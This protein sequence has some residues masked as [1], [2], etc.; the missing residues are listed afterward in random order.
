MSF[1]FR[2]DAFAGQQD[3]QTHIREALTNALNKKLPRILEDEITVLNLDWGDEAPAI[4]MLEIGDVALDRFRGVFKLNYTGGATITVATKVQANLLNVYQ[5][6]AP[7]QFTMPSFVDAQSSFPIPLHLTLRNIRLQGTVIVVFSKSKGLTLVFRNDP[8]QSIEVSSTFDTLPAIASYLQQ[9]IEAQIR[10]LFREELPA[11]LY[12]LSLRYLPSFSQSLIMDEASRFKNANKEHPVTFAEIEAEK[13]VSL[14]NLLH[15]E[16]MLSSRRTLALDTP[17]MP[18]AIV[19]SE[20][21][22]RS[23]LTRL[24]APAFNLVSD[25]NSVFDQLYYHVKHSSMRAAAQKP[26]RR[27]V[28]KL[29]KPKSSTEPTMELP[30]L[31]RPV[32]VEPPAT[33]LEIVPAS[34]VKHEAPVRAWAPSGKHSLESL[35]Q[36]LPVSQLMRDHKGMPPLSWRHPQNFSFSNTAFRNDDQTPLS[37]HEIDELPPAYVA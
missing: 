16:A 4:E 10:G 6:S 32:S 19:R 36:F 13:P 18:T 12:Q 5:H 26:P 17:I 11:M 25:D 2:W 27:R 28:I 7:S 33:D 37:V 9:Q 24:N 20:L 35:V 14:V 30:D 23:L 8:L 31:K 1:S 29:N 3:F 22:H 34:P 21:H 15:V